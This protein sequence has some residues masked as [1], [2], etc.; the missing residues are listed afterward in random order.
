MLRALNT[1]ATGMVAQQTN[2]DV[3]ANN[4]ANVN[5]TG[6][7]RAR[8]EFQ[9]LVYQTVRAPGGRTGDGGTLPTGVQLG[10]G[11]RTVSTTLI[12]SQGSLQQTDGPM[13]LAIEGD[14]YFQ[15]Q[16]PTGELAYTRSGNLHADAEGNLV[17]VDGLAIEPNITIPL[18]A[19]AITVTAD[20]TISVQVAGQPNAQEV[21]RLQ[22]AGFAN[23][24]GL[25]ATGRS[26][27]DQTDA[28][29][30]PIVATPGQEGL[31][32]IAQGFLEGSNVEVVNE[33]IDLI[34]S[35]RAYDINQKVIEAADEMLKRITR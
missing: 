19:T 9:D 27:F 31:G 30:Q 4:M 28:S 15:V 17:T 10:Q 34:S 8:A 29:G 32:T 35:Q 12:H 2:I 24:Q 26:L 13:D 3:T 7:R 20:G 16:R 25:L 14:G 22:L 23:P 33:M 1:A 5:T 11:T 18:D 21:G 6:F